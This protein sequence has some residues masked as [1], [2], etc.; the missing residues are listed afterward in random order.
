MIFG[1]GSDKGRSGLGW[2]LFSGTSRPTKLGLKVLSRLLD[3]VSAVSAG[4]IP[5]RHR[6]SSPHVSSGPPP[7][8]GNIVCSVS[9][10]GGSGV[11]PL[12]TTHVGS[13][14]REER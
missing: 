8:S 4:W 7:Y 6:H 3:V 1:L 11:G 5:H 2:R 9:F 13:E 12:P 14:E 10:P